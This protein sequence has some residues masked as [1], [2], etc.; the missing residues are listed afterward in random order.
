MSIVCLNLEKNKA[1]LIL[2]KQMCDRD[3]KFEWI[4]KYKGYPYVLKK[5]QKKPAVT[6]PP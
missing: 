3:E 5:K 6:N 1:Q 2:L 4:S